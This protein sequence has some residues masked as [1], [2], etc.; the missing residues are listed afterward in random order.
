MTYTKPEARVLGS[1]TAVVE[2]LPPTQKLSGVNDP[3][4]QRPNTIPAY[5][6]DE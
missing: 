2:S 6:L 5:D 3:Q 1:A 4:H